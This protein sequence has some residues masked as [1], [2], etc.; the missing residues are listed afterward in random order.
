MTLQII[1]FTFKLGLFLYDG[2]LE[3]MLVLELMSLT[4]TR[5]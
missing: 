1:T 2:F 5:V 4:V 3:V